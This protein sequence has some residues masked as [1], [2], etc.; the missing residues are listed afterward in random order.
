MPTSFKPGPT[1]PALSIASPVGA[2]S[3]AL[4][5]KFQAFFGEQLEKVAGT[6]DSEAGALEPI[7]AGLGQG[8]SFAVKSMEDA[9]VKRALR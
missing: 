5:P 2:T 9:P 7:R 1:S 6:E 8:D 3:S 4:F